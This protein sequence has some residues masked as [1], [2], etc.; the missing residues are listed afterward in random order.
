MIVYFDSSALIYLIEGARPLAEAVRARLQ[1]LMMRDPT[2]RAAVGRLALLE[3]RVRPMRTGD[4]ATLDAYD[5]FF[6][7]PDLICVELT[8]D[9]VDLATAIRAHHRLKTPDA[10]HAACC[11]QLGDDHAFLT[12]DVAFRG[13]P[14]LHV[15]TV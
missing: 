14:G 9:V 10:L 13:V 8:A 6:A 5:S 2:T 15:Q 12:G 1:T 11:L 4:A 7:R 3:C